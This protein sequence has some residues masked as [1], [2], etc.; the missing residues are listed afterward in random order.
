MAVAYLTYQII[1]GRIRLIDLCSKIL[2]GGDRRRSPSFRETLAN[3]FALIQ[4]EDTIKCH[5]QQVVL[6]S[7]CLGLSYLLR[8][9]SHNEKLLDYS[10]YL[11]TFTNLRI[12]Y[13]TGS[14]LSL[15]DL[16]SR[17]Y[18]KIVLKNNKQLISKTWAEYLPPLKHKYVGTEIT[19][20]MLQDLLS[21]DPQ[22]EWSDI[23]TKRSFYS[24]SLSRYH[25]STYDPTSEQVPIP[26]E[27][28]FL[29]SLYTGFNGEKLTPK[30]YADLLKSLENLPASQ[31][32]QIPAKNS[33]LNSLRKSL[34]QL[35][36]ESEVKKILQQKYDPSSY[37]SKHR[38]KCSKYIQNLDL[39]AD[40]SQIIRDALK[41][42]GC[43]PETDELTYFEP[44]NENATKENKSTTDA[45]APV[46]ITDLPNGSSSACVQETGT[47]DGTDACAPVQIT[48]GRSSSAGVQ[49][50]GSTQVT[51]TA[52][53]HN[54]NTNLTICALITRLTNKGNLSEQ[55]L[56]SS[57]VS[58]LED[59]NEEDLLLILG[60]DREKLHDTLLP[61]CNEVM[62]II[63]YMKT[64][65]LLAEKDKIHHLRQIIVF[66]VRIAFK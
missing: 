27:V 56:L 20:A 53:P 59:C 1:G 66:L 52:V 32:A 10:M 58:N 35:G 40:I 60:I 34:F 17:Q 6:L 25:K 21:Y 36:I 38:M 51:A 44:K 2:Q 11:S 3:I 61:V 63:Y 57:F 46:H 9:K 22:A 15:C 7:D 29:I 49:K 13:T 30:Q 42:A 65:T 24:Q 19:Q 4:N 8:N 43:N 45:C 62:K 37:F 54:Q 5:P 50:S 12:H 33:N 31:L 41:N 23:W 48:G 26:V 18:N 55:Q 28:D 14:S 16:L 39:P 64:G 47:R